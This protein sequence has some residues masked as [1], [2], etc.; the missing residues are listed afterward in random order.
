VTAPAVV[1]LVLSAVLENVKTD[2]HTNYPVLYK[3]YDYGGSNQARRQLTPL[4]NNK[5]QAWSMRV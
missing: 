5:R 4:A 2:R 3:C 1:T